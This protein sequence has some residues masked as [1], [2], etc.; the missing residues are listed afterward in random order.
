MLSK[1]LSNNNFYQKRSPKEFSVEIMMP[2]T[3]VDHKLHTHSV[4]KESESIKQALF[5]KFDLKKEELHRI[6][7][8]YTRTLDHTGEHFLITKIIF[9]Y[10][11]GDGRAVMNKVTGNNWWKK[12]V[13]H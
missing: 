1:I 4:Q 6:Q 7:V 3:K 13:L 9:L 11:D 10:T 12:I 2:A 8:E 5:K